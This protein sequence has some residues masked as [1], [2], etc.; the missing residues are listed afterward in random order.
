MFGR[1]HL[2][3]ERA[4]LSTPDMVRTPS[5]Q[6]SRKGRIAI[7]HPA[8]S[9]RG[10]IVSQPIAPRM[11]AIIHQTKKGCPLPDI[12]FLSS[13]ELKLFQQVKVKWQGYPDFDRFAGLNAWSH[14][15]VADL[16][17][18]CSREDRMRLL[19]HDVFYIVP[20]FVNLNA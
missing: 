7:C 16:L 19:D 20:V 2:Y 9:V 6:E 12:P 17:G 15:E 5:V 1:I 18:D 11:L 14:F 4:F 3:W 13:Y 10:A 8:S